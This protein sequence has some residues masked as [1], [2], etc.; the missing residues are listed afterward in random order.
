VENLSKDATADKPN[1]VNDSS[2]TPIDR[3]VEIERLAALD[4]LD[5]EI[6]RI[7]AA[8]RLGFRAEKLDK[9]VK[10]TRHKLG[11]EG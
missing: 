9:F 2:E 5:Y 3:V 8:D 7:E 1:D 10:K 11:L 4:P 6:A